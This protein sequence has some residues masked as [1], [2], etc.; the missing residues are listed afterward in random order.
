MYI[1]CY[2]QLLTFQIEDAAPDS[3]V[4]GGDGERAGQAAGHL[5]HQCLLRHC[6]RHQESICGNKE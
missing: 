1:I 5:Q 3:L 6:R 2:D 4:E